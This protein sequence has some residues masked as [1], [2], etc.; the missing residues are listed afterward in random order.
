MPLIKCQVRVVQ[1]HSIEPWASK[2][3][4][5]V[6]CEEKKLD[7]YELASFIFRPCLCILQQNKECSFCL[8]NEEKNPFQLSRYFNGKFLVVFDNHQ[9]SALDIPL[10]FPACVESCHEIFSVKQIAEELLEEFDLE[11]LVPTF[12]DKESREQFDRSYKE[13]QECLTQIVCEPMS[14]T[15][16]AIREPT[17]ALFPQPPPADFS[18]MHLSFEKY[19]ECNP[20]VECKNLKMQICDPL[21]V[22]CITRDLY[23]RPLME[24]PK[25]QIIKLD[26]YSWDTIKANQALPQLVVWG[27]R[28]TYENLRNYLSTFCTYQGKEDILTTDKLNVLVIVCSLSS[29]KVIYE[30]SEKLKMVE[31][32]CQ[33]YNIQNVHFANKYIWGISQNRIARI[34]GAKEFC[35]SLYQAPKYLEEQIRWDRSKGGEQEAG[36][37]L[38]RRLPPCLPA[39]TSAVINPGLPPTFEN[40]ELSEIKEKPILEESILCNDP[41]IRKQTKSLLDSYSQLWAKDAFSVGSFRDKASKKICKFDLKFTKLAPYFERPRWNSPLK[42]TAIKEVLG[43]LLKQGVISPGVSQWAN[44]PVFVTK[45]APNI[46]RDEW[47]KRGKSPESWVPGTPDPLA[48]IK[49]RLTLDLKRCNEMQEDIP[50]SPCDPRQLI[51][52]LENNCLLSTLDCSLAFNSLHLSKASAMVCSH[53]SGL[54]DNTCFQH[55]RVSMGSKQSSA[56]L[57]A[58][59]TNANLKLC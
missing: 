29:R 40:K 49:L 38:S 16:C 50:I 14:F 48:D 35:I 44:C 53:Y 10:S 4:A 33:K 19:K 36:N 5:F 55:N 7:G 12:T 27:L 32:L 18:T 23:E 20:C 2:E 24:T 46:S 6:P 25:C 57:K 26:L 56:M 31:G 3:I 28:P 59:L 30:S 52:A 37:Q 22:K 17:L 43:G 41:E 39:S 54:P 15:R 47:I 21:N 9:M 11:P 8:E 58:S 1:S 42:R 13:M 51:A 45:R 34:F